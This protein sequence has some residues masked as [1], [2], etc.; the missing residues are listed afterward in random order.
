MDYI[1]LGLESKNLFGTV[2]FNGGYKIDTRDKKNKR[3]FG[4]SLQSLYPIID[5][6]IEGSNDFYFQDQILNDR[7]GNPV[8]TI[9]NADIN[10]KAKDL[11]LGLR[12]PL[13]Y[14]KGK[15]FTNL[16][17]KSNINFANN[18][19]KVTILDKETGISPGQACVF[20][21]KDQFGHK[22]LGGGWI[23]D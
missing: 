8:D 15:Y 19:A 9:Y 12:L 23:K 20:Y 11:S 14:T 16:I 7:E 17:L 1:T 22:V 18:S 6:S 13:S 4:I 10:F 5:M 3:F 21:K 2:V